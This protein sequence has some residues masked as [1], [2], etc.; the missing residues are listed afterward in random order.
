MRSATDLD[1]EA[2]DEGDRVLWDSRL[3]MAFEKVDRPTESSFFLEDTPVQTF[4]DVGG[5]DTQIDKL[6][7]SIRLRRQHPEVVR[8]YRLKQVRSVLMVGAPGTGK[9]LLA[10][11]FANWIAELSPSGRSRFMNIKPAALHSPWYAESEANYREI[12]RVAREAGRADPEVPV[13]M[14]F[15]EID[16]VGSSRTPSSHRVNDRVLTALMT[17]LDGLEDRGN[18]LVLAATNRADALDPRAAS[19]RTP[20]GPGPRG[21]EA[22]PGGGRTHPREAPVP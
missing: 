12:F 1:P 8:R 14:F 16:S 17:E 19:S 10:R 6:K 11:A 7:R 18:I 2:L 9:T 13:V 15:D 22:R 20:Q 21:A 3:Q 5:L 4:D